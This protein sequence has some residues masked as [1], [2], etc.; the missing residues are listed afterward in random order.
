[1]IPPHDPDGD[2]PEGVHQATWTEFTERFCIFARSDRRLRLCRQIECMFDEASASQVV[3]RILFGGSFVT[4][5]AEPNDFDC[6]IVL[7]T[8]THYEDLRPFQRWVAD[9]REASRRYGGDVFVAR[10]NHPSMDLY[11][12]FF[13]L[14]RRGKHVGLVEVNV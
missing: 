10:A 1:M 13:R 9:T 2:L 6:I 3:E 5:E 12:D 4:A 8:E 7:K 14:N 11:V